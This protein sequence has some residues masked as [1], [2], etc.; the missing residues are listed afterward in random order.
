MAIKLTDEQLKVVKQMVR[1]SETFANNLLNIMENHGLDKIDGCG[2][3]IQ[4]SP[5]Y[6]TI[7]CM[8][9]VGEKRSDFGYVSVKRGKGEKYY[10]Y[11]GSHSEE[12]EILSDGETVRSRKEEYCKTEKPLPPD[13]LWVGDPRNDYPV[14]C[15][16]EWDVNDS[17]S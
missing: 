17:L 9:D 11:I 3:N 1:L 12:Y 15:R 8:V 13:G 16:W 2:L 6:E 14:D 5:Q 7:T 4:V 10:D